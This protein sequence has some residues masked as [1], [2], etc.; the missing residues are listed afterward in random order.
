MVDEEERFDRRFK[1]E[2]KSKRTI[3]KSCVS[4]PGVLV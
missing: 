3:G 2:K 4:S 1:K